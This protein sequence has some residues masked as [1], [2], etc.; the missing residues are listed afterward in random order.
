MSLN[1][2][3]MGERYK[4]EW[5]RRL[6]NENKLCMIGIQESKLGESTPTLN[7]TDCWGDWEYGFEQVF[8]TGRSGGLVSIWDRK[9]FLVIETIKSRY[10]IA[11]LGN[12]VGINGL[13][14][15]LNVYGPKSEIDKSNVWAEL[16]TLKSSKSA[17]WIFIG[18]FNV[19][20][21][22][23]ERIN[24]IFCMRSANDFNHFIC[25]SKLNDLKMGGQRFTYFQTRGAKLSKLD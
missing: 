2:R 22:S 14:G 5:V 18:D 13:T 21:R 12:F 7:V 6:R 15:F 24:S 19:V 17:T 1:I 11:V 16:L 4:I 8:T 23:E 3:G 10:F 20:R 9:Q 25:L